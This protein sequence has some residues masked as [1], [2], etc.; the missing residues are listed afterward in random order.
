MTISSGNMQS[1]LLANPEITSE[2]MMAGQIK[3]QT[4][5]PEATDKAVGEDEFWGMLN[6][7]LTDITSQGD[8]QVIEN[9]ELLAMFIEF[10]AAL[11]NAEGDDNAGTHWL[12]VL[13][14]H[15]A[16]VGVESSPA[17]EG[18]TPDPAQTEESMEMPLMA[19]LMAGNESAAKSVEPGAGLPRVRQMLSAEMQ[20]GVDAR[21][22]QINEKQVAHSAL[23]SK[24][25]LP[26]E[27]ED[28]G[29][30]RLTMQ[31]A[32]QD[33]KKFSDMG[34]EKILMKQTLAEIA[35]VQG[36]DNAPTVHAQASQPVSMLQQPQ[37]SSQLPSVL[38]SLQVSPQTPSTE[39]GNALGERISF[40]I[41]NRLNSAEIRIDPP[42]LGKLDI[43]I[44]VKEDTALVVI[45][46][47]HAQTKELI[48]SASIRLREFLQEAGYNSVD[49]NVSHHDQS[50]GDE[51][52]AANDQSS[53]GEDSAAQN[54]SD[55]SPDQSSMQQGEMF[56]SVD[57]GRIDYFV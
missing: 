22:P 55:T 28:G 17:T 26:M 41:N 54:N 2:G 48:D 51:D 25:G 42:H 45:N 36:K 16:D 10:E 46:T 44:Q 31:M 6:Q 4:I 43:Q 49:V 33:E 32:A 7:Q 29:Q 8:A 56:I 53:Q 24:Q 37:S 14:S 50:M 23:H 20:P 40:L 39:W 19:A 57:D 52:F 12:Q 30:Q 1:V 47:Q 38:Q 13:K 15:F 27:G 11:E 5:T 3:A 18:S 35:A 9:K 34:R 21:I